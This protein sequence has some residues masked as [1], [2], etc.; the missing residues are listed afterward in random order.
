MPDA[1]KSINRSTT[2][3]NVADAALLT[4][5]SPLFAIPI[6]LLMGLGDYT[7]MV[8]VGLAVF[9]FRFVAIPL[10]FLFL[11]NCVQVTIVRS[12]CTT[13]RAIPRVLSPLIA[14]L[15]FLAPFLLGTARRLFF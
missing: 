5:L 7:E 14:T 2:I 1:P 3:R 4:L 11:L 9:Y 10:M 8:A 12:V 15:L 13:S 6:L